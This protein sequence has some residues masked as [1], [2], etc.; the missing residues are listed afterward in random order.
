M[1]TP[2][3]AVNRALGVSE[4]MGT[5][6]RFWHRFSD[7]P[8]GSR[9]SSSFAGDARVD[10]V[11]RRIAK[12]VAVEARRC[13]HHLRR[14]RSVA[15]VKPEARPRAR[16]RRGDQAIAARAEA[17][18][19]STG[20]RCQTLKVRPKVTAKNLGRTI[21]VRV[22][23]NK[24]YLY[25]GFDVIRTFGGRDGQARLHDPQGDWNIYP[26]GGEPHLVQPGARQL[27]GRSSR[28]R[29]GWADGTHGHAGDLHRR[30]PG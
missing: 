11:P 22:D 1:P 9:S 28:G 5:F 19:P 27:G 7:E 17:A 8:V 29:P 21:V 15:F 4:S 30:R 14:R 24:L 2:S 25:D 12:D 6:S 26:Q 18:T 3:A 13:R 16:L 10:A 20:S 23:E